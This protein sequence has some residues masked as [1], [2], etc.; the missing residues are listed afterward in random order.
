MVSLL[1][2]RGDA[3][4]ALREWMGQCDALEGEMKRLQGEE[5]RRLGEAA[6]RREED[7]WAIVRGTAWGVRGNPRG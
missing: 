3:E 7:R 4:T 1:S 2:S 5:L 6:K